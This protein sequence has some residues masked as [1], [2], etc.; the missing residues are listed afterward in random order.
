MEAGRAGAHLTHQ[1]EAEE[2]SGSWIERADPNRV[3]V[4]FLFFISIFFKFVSSSKFKSKF[5]FN[6]LFLNFKFPS[7]YNF[8][9]LQYIY[10]L[11]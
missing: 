9:Y 5:K 3:L 6:P 11:F 4:F 2:A 7:K 1:A 10:L 8:Y